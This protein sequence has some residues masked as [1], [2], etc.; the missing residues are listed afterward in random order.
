MEC[1]PFAVAQRPPL[2]CNVQCRFLLVPQSLIQVERILALAAVDGHESGTVHP[3]RPAYRTVIEH[4]VDPC[5]PEE[6]VVLEVLGVLLV[7]ACLTLFGHPVRAGC[8][9][10]RIALVSDEAAAPVTDSRAEV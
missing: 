5:A 6:R 10:C 9:L 7:E 2:V 4:V 1:L 3:V 8:R